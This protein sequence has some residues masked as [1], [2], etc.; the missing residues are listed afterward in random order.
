MSDFFHVG[1]VSVLLLSYDHYGK[2]GILILNRNPVCVSILRMKGC[3]A[4]FLIVT[5][6]V[7]CLVNTC[8][9]GCQI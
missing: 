6:G 4:G 3:H 9:K 7:D 5:E 8:V 2:T 1:N